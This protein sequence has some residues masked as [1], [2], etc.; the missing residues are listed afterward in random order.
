MNKKKLDKFIHLAKVQKNLDKVKGV[1]DKIKEN[2][3]PCTGGKRV[4]YNNVEWKEF[5]SIYNEIFKK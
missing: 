3:T 5:E 2:S 1:F 4:T